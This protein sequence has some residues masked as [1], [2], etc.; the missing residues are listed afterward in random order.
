MGAEQ[1]FQMIDSLLLFQ[2][3]VFEKDSQRRIV[4]AHVDRFRIVSNCATFEF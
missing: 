2:H 1:F 4:L 3:N